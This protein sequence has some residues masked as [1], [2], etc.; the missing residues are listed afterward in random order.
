M[1]K[2]CPI[3]EKR[4]NE[5]VARLNAIVTFVLVGIFALTG[6]LFIIGFLLL[7][8][9]SRGFIDG[10]M[11]LLNLINK[12]AVN[13]F[14]LETRMINAGPK[15]FAAQVGSTLTFIIAFASVLGNAYIALAFASIL[16]F[17]SLLEGAFGVC[18]ACKMYPIIRKAF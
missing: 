15:I 14:R 4:V 12:Q 16:G 2:F 6:N 18:V 17:F 11:S 9:I 7:D 8:F 1:E 5:K 10:R 3:T 13:I